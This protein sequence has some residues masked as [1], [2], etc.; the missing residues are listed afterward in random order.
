MKIV[1]Y[2]CKIVN[3]FKL[4]QSVTFYHDIV[5]LLSLFV[6]ARDASR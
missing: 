2:L 1:A 4:Q 5:S 3:Q 6:S